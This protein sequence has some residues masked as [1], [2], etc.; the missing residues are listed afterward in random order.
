VIAV[1]LIAGAQRIQEERCENSMP[2]RSAFSENSE[3]VAFLLIFV[4]GR[5]SC[6]L[7]HARC[8]YAERF[9]YNDCCKA[10]FMNLLKWRSQCRSHRV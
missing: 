1:E 4:A 3:N 5:A 10:F 6:S 7:S 8:P 9:R 2:L